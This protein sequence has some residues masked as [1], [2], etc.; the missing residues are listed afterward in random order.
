MQLST[1]NIQTKFIIHIQWHE[2]RRWSI[3]L[4]CWQQQLIGVVVLGVCLIVHTRS[5]TYSTCNVNSYLQIFVMLILSYHVSNNS[6]IDFCKCLPGPIT[7]T[8][9]CRFFFCFVL[10]LLICCIF[11]FNDWLALRCHYHV[12]SRNSRICSYLEQSTAN[13]DLHC[14]TQ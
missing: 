7:F 8:I 4:H 2:Y 9:A 12:M 5:V 3:T 10:L 13:N 11:V 1:R 14:N 6:F